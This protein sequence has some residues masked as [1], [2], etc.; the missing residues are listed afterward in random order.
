MSESGWRAAALC[1]TESRGAQR[2][3]VVRPWAQ[4]EAAAYDL[5]SQ[6]PVRDTAKGLIRAR[7]IKGRVKTTLPDWFAMA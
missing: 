2:E 3:A 7:S 6:D 5:L 1:A 4:A